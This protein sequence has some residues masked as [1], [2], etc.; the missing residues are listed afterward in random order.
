MSFEENEIFYVYALQH[1][2]TKKIYIGSTDR[3]QRRYK[4]HLYA[5]RKG[6]HSSKE[7]QKDFEKYGEDFSVYILEEVT[8][9]K[10]SVMEYGERSISLIHKRE[11]YWMKKYRTIYNGYNTQDKKAIKYI[12]NSYT[13]ILP[14]KEGLPDITINEES[15]NQ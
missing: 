14:L 15:E 6:K 9:A 7:L 2:I 11:Y 13:F 8:N 3:L 12:E 5:L 1:N 10:S 4:N